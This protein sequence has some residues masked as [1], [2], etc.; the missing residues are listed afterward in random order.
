M[1]SGPSTN[2]A[3]G[4]RIA[5]RNRPS[6]GVTQAEVGAS[7]EKQARSSASKP[8]VPPPGA[9]SCLGRGGQFGVAR[10][11]AGVRWRLRSALTHLGVRSLTVLGAAFAGTAPAPRFSGS[12]FGAPPS[13]GTARAPRSV[14]LGRSTGR[15]GRT[16]GRQTAEDGRQDPATQV[17]LDVDRAVEAG[18]GGEAA[19]GAVVG[20]RS[21]GHGLLGRRSAASPLTVSRSRPVRPSDAAESPALNW[22][23]RIP[24]PT[25]FERWIR[26]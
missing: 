6:I 7:H 3:E 12:E 20:G 25:R 15:L 9:S 8:P 10:G 16:L 5:S 13:H 21:D 1:D 23:G 22:S 19:L 2:A 11:G 24:I 18:D 17:V 14:T 4:S 26:S